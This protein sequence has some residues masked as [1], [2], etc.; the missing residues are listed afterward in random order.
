[1]HSN[2]LHMP[3]K[4]LF[5]LVALKC[6]WEWQNWSPRYIVL[7]MYVCGERQNWS[8]ANAYSI[9]LHM[10]IMCLGM[11]CLTKFICVM[12][13]DMNSHVFGYSHVC[14]AHFC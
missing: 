2:L 5:K 9:V 4:C 6:V 12:Y 1:M 7:H 8:L 3:S 10:S 13:L 11:V 14:V